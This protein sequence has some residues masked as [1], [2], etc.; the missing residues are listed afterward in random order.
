MNN[1]KDFVSYSAGGHVVRTN[2]KETEIASVR[3]AAKAN[4]EKATGDIKKEEE[5]KGLAKASPKFKPARRRGRPPK[6]KAEAQKVID[7]NTEKKE[8]EEEETEEE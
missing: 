4:L 6:D 1:R 7:E 5:P 2:D 8:E 3:D